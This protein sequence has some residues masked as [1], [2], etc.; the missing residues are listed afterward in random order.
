MTASKLD[1]FQARQFLVSAK[2]YNIE[3]NQVYLYFVISRNC[4][5][6]KLSCLEAVVLRNRHILRL[7]KRKTIVS[8]KVLSLSLKRGQPVFE[9]RAFKL[10]SMFDQVPRSAIVPCISEL[11]RDSIVLLALSVSSIL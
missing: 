10:K 5:A 3:S 7:P 4:H 8:E 1:G 9:N 11:S 2:G 6:W